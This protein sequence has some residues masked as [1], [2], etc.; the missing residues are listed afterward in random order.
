MTERET[1]A[2]GRQTQS[3]NGVNPPVFGGGGFCGFDGSVSR[4]L[5]LIQLAVTETAVR[6]PKVYLKPGRNGNLH[7]NL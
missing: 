5:A 1:R 6:R 7:Q 4:A 2:A 3:R